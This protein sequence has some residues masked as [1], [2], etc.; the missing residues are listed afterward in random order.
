MSGGEVENGQPLD[1]TGLDIPVN[2]ERA[3]EPVQV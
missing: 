2:A 1:L 3:V